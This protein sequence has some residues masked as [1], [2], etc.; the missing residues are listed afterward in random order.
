MSVWEVVGDVDYGKLIDKFGSQ[1]I[2]P[3]QLE[4]CAFVV[5]LHATFVVLLY[6]TTE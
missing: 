6:I 1:A 5:L 4:R 3:E 2:T